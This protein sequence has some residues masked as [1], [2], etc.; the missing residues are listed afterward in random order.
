MPP[1]QHARRRTLA[2][3]LLAGLT[4]APSALAETPYGLV[5]TVVLDA[6]DTPQGNV[7]LVVDAQYDDTQYGDTQYGDTQYIAF[8]MRPRR[9]SMHPKRP[10][11]SPSRLTSRLPRRRLMPLRW[12]R[13]W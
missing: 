1:H 6:T 10:R 12:P 9:W 4:A 13:P 11:Q 2:L 8:Q 3:A 5:E 7:Q